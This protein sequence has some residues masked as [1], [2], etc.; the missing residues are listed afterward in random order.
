MSGLFRLCRTRKNPPADPT[1]VSFA[2]KTVVITG[3]TSGLG[4][5]AAIKHLN[6]GVDTLIIGSRNRK[7]GDETKAELEMRTNRLGVIQVWELEMDKFES[8]K[9][10]AKRVDVEVP[11]V[12]VALLNAGLWNREYIATAEGWE[13]ALQVNALSTCFLALLLLPKLRRSASVSGPAHLT[14]VSSQQFTRVRAQSLR[15]DGPLLK[16]LNSPE[17][18]NGRNQYGISKLLV[19]YLVKEIASLT[20]NDDGTVQVIVNSVSP[21]FCAS[22]LVRQYNKMYERMALWIV[23]KLF[24]RT[25]EQGSRSLVSATFQGVESQGKCWRS[26]GYLE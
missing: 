20:R 25:A 26:D 21:G 22:S 19:E 2:G 17:S 23:F 11:R 14:V 12:D 24:G 7:R 18:Y 4:F 10:F 9:D 3:A 5:E 8:V 1:E 6:L 16:H 13:E 15:C